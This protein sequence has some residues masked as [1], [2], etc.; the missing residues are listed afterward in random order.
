MGDSPPIV[1]TIQRYYPGWQPP[2]GRG[3]WISCLCPFHGDS[4]KS[5]SI[6]LQLNAFNC[7]VCGVKGDVIKILREQEGLSY[8]DAKQLAE[9]L[10]EGGDGAVQ[11]EPARQSR[12]GLFSDTGPGDIISSRPSRDRPVH[13]GV[14]GRTTPWS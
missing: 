5:A 7:F 11:A 2:K 10:A 3:K 12:R 1:R 14:R 13:A 4:N 8:S 6:S 9:E